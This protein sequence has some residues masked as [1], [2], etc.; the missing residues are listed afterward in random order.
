[1]KIKCLVMFLV[2]VMNAHTMKRK[3]VEIAFDEYIKR[4]ESIT[5]NR[6]SKD[7]IAELR[8]PRTLKDYDPDFAIKHASEYKQRRNYSDNSRTLLIEKW[9][10]HNPH[11]LWRTDHELHHIIPLGYGGRNEWWNV[12]PLTFHDHR[13]DGSGIHSSEEFKQLFP[14]VKR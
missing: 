3:Q 13:A 14:N 11:L 9:K 8:R 10:E 1:M 7:Q 6:L 2:L 4:M 5:G 12:F